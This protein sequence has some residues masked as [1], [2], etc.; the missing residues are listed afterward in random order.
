MLPLYTQWVFAIYFV[1]SCEVHYEI[2]YVGFD[3]PT[4]NMAVKSSYFFC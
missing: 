3:K 1:S 4:L 2:S